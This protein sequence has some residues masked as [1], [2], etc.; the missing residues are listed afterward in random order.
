V[1]TITIIIILITHLRGKY[2]MN[3]LNGAATPQTAV[4]SVKTKQ[5][6][7]GVSINVQELF[8]MRYQN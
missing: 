3:R 5:F 8:L 2:T 7:V 6:S 1:Q 4:L